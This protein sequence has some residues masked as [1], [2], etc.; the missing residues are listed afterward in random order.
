MHYM[1]YMYRLGYLIFLIPCLLITMYSLYP[2]CHCL[3]SIRFIMPYCALYTQVIHYE[4]A[5]LCL[6]LHGY[7]SRISVLHFI[8]LMVHTN[9]SYLQRFYHYPHVFQWDSRIF[10]ILPK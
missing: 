3:I 9:F 2:V 8:S 5:K 4:S 1:Y 7:K 6:L 10:F